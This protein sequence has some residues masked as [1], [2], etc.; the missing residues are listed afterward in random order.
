[1]LSV[2]S[3][4]GTAGIR[5]MIPI[6]R[7]VT[8]VVA[9]TALVFIGATRAQAQDAAGE[10][11]TPPDPALLLDKDHEMNP[12]LA[13]SLDGLTGRLDYFWDPREVTI[14]WSVT[15]ADDFVRVMHQ[16]FPVNVW[17]TDLCGFEEDVLLVTGKDATTGQT[18]IERW[19]FD[20][21]ETLPLAYID[22]ASG[23]LIH[24]EPRITIEKTRVVYADSTRGP[25]R[26]ML[27]RHGT[28]SKVLLHLWDDKS[29][30]SYDVETG[31]YELL[32]HPDPGHGV[33]SVPYLATLSGSR[34]SR[35]HSVEGYVYGFGQVDPDHTLIL[36]DHDLDGDF[37]DVVEGKSEGFEVIH[38][39]TFGARRLDEADLYVK[40]Y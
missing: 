22:L 8:T 39:I 11:A 38:F 33:P 10:S 12:R 2:I 27:R 15:Y 40:L 16:S 32:Y 36:F 17:V 7:A 28:A 9:S 14:E 19:D 30:G 21:P 6:M 25:V 37:D 3:S 13:T 26:V 1:M 23:E 24:P 4:K 34:W 18:V 5:P 35:H 20:V 31:E 29:L